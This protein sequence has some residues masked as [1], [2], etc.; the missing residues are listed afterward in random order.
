MTYSIC[1]I[2][3]DG[4]GQEVIPAAAEVLRA[5]GLPIEFGWAD[6]GWA[7][8]ERSGDAL[9]T[10][11]VEAIQACGVAMF[12]ATQSPMSKVAGYRSPILAL[13]KTFDLYANIRPTRSLPVPSARQG[14]DFV[15]VRENTEGLYAGR[16]RREGDTAIAERVITRR[17]SERIVRVACE[18]AMRR[19]LPLPLGEG[20]GEGLPP[21]A[22]SRRLTLVHKANVLGITDGL[23]REAARAVAAE[24]PDLKVDELLVDAAAMWLVKAPE[25]FDVLVTTNLFGDILSDL[26]AGLVGGLGV[27][28]SANIG[29]EVA[30]FEP[31]HGSA[32]DIAGQGVANPV[33]AILSAAMLL[34]HLGERPAA[35]RVNRAVERTVAAGICTPD[36]GGK[37]TTREVTASIISHLQ[38]SS[39]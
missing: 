4:V 17:A 9:P 28:P 37:A 35:E 18:L 33:G 36:L 5:T 19:S 1:L 11:T 12:G 24:Y 2:P 39:L 14:L 6:A 22:V 38:S 21:S 3:G 31:V 20:R 10:A 34:D 15:I 26:A 8:F 30:V 25:R 29:P 23:F 32:P 13:R 16:E 7:C 27:A